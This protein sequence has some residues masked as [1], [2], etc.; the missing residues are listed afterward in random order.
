MILLS[1]HYAP[2]SKSRRDELAEVRE[3]NEASGLF[4]QCVYVDGDK[5]RWTYGDF[6]DLAAQSLAGQVCVLANSDIRFDGTIRLLE[7]S[8]QK[9]RL[10][11]LTRWDSLVSPRMLGHTV[12][13]RFFSGTQDTWI[14]VGGGTGRTDKMSS[15]PLGF[16]GCENAFL[17]EAVLAGCEVFNPAIDIRTWHV[18]REPPPE[19]RRSVDGWFVY[20]ELT[21]VVSSGEAFAHFFPS[22]P[23]GPI[24]AKVI[25]TW[26]Q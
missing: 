18:H 26:R 25:S 3:A 20:P 19:N 8:C 11:A 22:E 10:F 15:I 4:E 13:E 16:V 12:G 23:D 1:Q 14:F 7:A 17:G 24:E 6:I 2:A 5:K 21:T 9:M